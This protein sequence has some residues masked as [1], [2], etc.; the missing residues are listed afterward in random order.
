MRPLF[1]VLIV[2]S[3]PLLQGQLLTRSPTSK[4]SY[5]Q[6]LLLTKPTTYKANYLQGLLRKGPY[7]GAGAKYSAYNTDRRVEITLFAQLLYSRSYF[8]RAVTCRR[9][10]VCSGQRGEHDQSRTS[11]SCVLSLAFPE[12]ALPIWHHRR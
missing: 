3:H 8:T 10:L 1:H 7:T 12:Y 5:L 11:R 4:A 9:S 6:G 2:Y